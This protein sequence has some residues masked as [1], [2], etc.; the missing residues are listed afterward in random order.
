MAE[1]PV[2]EKT[3]MF[4]NILT[5][6]GLVILIAIIVWGLFHLETLS[7]SWLSSFA[8]MFSPSAK[9]IQITA[10]SNKLP[11]GEEFPVSWK[12]T[13]KNAGKYAF[14]YQCREGF[15]FKTFGTGSKTIAIPCGVGYTMPGSNNKFNVIPFLNGLSSL[16]VPFSI[17][18]IPNAP[19]AT[20]TPMS[21]AEGNASVTII[22]PSLAASPAKPVPEPAPAPAS[23]LPD[24]SVR[25]LSKGVIDPISGNLI[26]RPPT[27]PNEL[28]AVR[29]LISND[30]SAST[31]TWYFTAQLP[32]SPAYLY[33]SPAQEPLAQGAR[34]ENMLRFK[35]AVPGGTFYVSVDPVD[36]V[37]ESSEINNTASVTI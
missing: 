9:F 1:K 21:Q 8:S 32:I 15:Q 28:V 11:S 37:K 2:A 23:G 24:L 18:F 4:S 13:P 35:N 10:P 12:Y 20:G 26:A 16:D 19:V 7:K 6:T 31:G 22:N 34:I 29:F 33:S 36:E 14:L 27:S 5:V 17:I 3:G 25:I 30:G